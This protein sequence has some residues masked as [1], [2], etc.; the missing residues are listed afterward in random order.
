[1][2]DATWAEFARMATEKWQPEADRVLMEL[3]TTG[4]N[5]VATADRW[6]VFDRINALVSA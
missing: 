4:F 6:S 5:Q 1:M 3:G 2:P